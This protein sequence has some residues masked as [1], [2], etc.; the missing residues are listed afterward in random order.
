MFLPPAFDVVVKENNTKDLACVNT[1]RII[2]AAV[3]D[4]LV[5]GWP[6]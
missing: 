2:M 3:G 6:D 1:T 5:L 4:W